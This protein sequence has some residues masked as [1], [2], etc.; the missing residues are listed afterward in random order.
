MFFNENFHIFFIKI[1]MQMK[2]KCIN[3]KPLSFIGISITRKLFWVYFSFFF[4]AAWGFLSEI[5]CF[6]VGTSL[7]RM[8]IRS[9]NQRN[10][11]LERYMRHEHL[12][13]LFYNPFFFFF[14]SN[15][16]CFLCSVCFFFLLS[17]MLSWIIDIASCHQ[18]V[19]CLYTLLFS[20]S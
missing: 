18:V 4:A 2:K 17:P 8:K 15:T 6:G 10:D 3:L 11:K 12:K 13:K 20:V 5:F 14:F 9:I 19:V 16:L 7:A 1:Y